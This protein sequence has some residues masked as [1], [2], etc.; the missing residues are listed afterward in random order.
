MKAKINHS[1][2]IVLLILTTT[3]L[4]QDAL[5]QNSKATSSKQNYQLPA[6]SKWSMFGPARI[7]IQDFAVSEKYGDTL[8]AGRNVQSSKTNFSI[9]IGFYQNFSKKLALSAELMFGHGYISRKSPTADDAKLSWSQTLRTDVYYHFYKQEMPLLPYLFAG[10]HGTYKM[11]NIYV[12]TPIGVGARYLLV[13]NN[14]LLTAQVG[15]GIGLTSS[16]RNSV[17]YSLGF[18]LNMR[19]N[20]K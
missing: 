18:Y 14:A 7:S 4:L 6:N 19:K 5:A 8:S 20:K 17:M 1:R 16:I 12:S 15:Y 11:G 9:G 3:L 2:W 13:N 10:V